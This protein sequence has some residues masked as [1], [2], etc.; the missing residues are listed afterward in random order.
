MAS[1]PLKT[2]MSTKGQVI[3]PKAT[4]DRQHLKPGVE[5]LVEETPAG[6]LLKPQ[7]LFPPKT[8][9]EV[10]GMLKGHREGPPPSVEE[11]DEAVAEMF[12][13]EYARGR[14]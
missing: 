9:D 7:P 4:R 10:A 12:R 5:F 13:E 2:R 14:Y 8:I 1:N 3:L 11:M 6:I